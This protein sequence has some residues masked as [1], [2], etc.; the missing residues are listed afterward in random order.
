MQCLVIAS[1]V[2]GT[3]KRAA[4]WISSQASP[5]HI[6]WLLRREWYFQLNV[7]IFLRKWHSSHVNTDRLFISNIKYSLS[8]NLD[9]REICC[10]WPE[11][12]HKWVGAVIWTLFISLV[13]VGK[14]VIDMLC[15]R[16]PRHVRQLAEGVG[17]GDISA[18]Q[19]QFSQVYLS[20]GTRCRD[21]FPPVRCSQYVII[22]FS[23][24]FYSLVPPFRRGS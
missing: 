8:F 3:P 13:I 20:V 18:R 14:A 4:R 24:W 21:T 22:W 16:W 15:L 7:I 2:T 23:S 11:T 17:D 9:D 6:C 5:R 19:C 1:K 12:N 10:C